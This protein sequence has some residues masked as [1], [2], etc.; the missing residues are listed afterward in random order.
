MGVYC[1]GLFVRET[2]YQHGDDDDDDD[3]DEKRIA[4]VI[5]SEAAAIRTHPLPTK[6]V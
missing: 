6:S 4:V 5:S 2:L 1:V 3:D